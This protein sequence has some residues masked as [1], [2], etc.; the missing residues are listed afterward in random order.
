MDYGYYGHYME[1]PEE[2]I[3]NLIPQPLPPVERPPMYRSTHNHKLPPSYSTFGTKGTSKLQANTTGGD[4]LLDCSGSKH[5]M[6]KPHA[7]MGR[8][9]GGCDPKR[10]LKRGEGVPQLPEARRF[11]RPDA[12]AKR[13]AVP[14]RT[15]KPVMGLMTEKNFVVANAVDNILAAAKKQKPEPGRPTQLPTYGKPPKYLE[16]VKQQL[17]EEREL[18]HNY[19]GDTAGSPG[20]QRMRELSDDERQELVANLKQKWE[21][22]HKQYLAMTFSLDTITKVQRKEALEAELE[23]LEKAIAK[24]SKKIIYVYDDKAPQW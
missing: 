11:E 20:G 19:G 23:Q 6:C 14:R 2:S 21:N 17:A 12:A 3:Y 8:R 10:F 9:S 18:V 1:E 22:T 24:M 16:R 15:E 7:T 4:A 5:K 13:P